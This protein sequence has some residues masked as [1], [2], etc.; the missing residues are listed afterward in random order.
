MLL[1]AIQYFVVKDVLHDSSEKKLKWFTG[2]FSVCNQV[3]F[4][5]SFYN[6][7]SKKN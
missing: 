7:G 3:R 5:A 6:F 2:D 1:F 4:V